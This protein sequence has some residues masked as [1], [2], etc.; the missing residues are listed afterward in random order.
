MCP[1]D[2]QT[3]ILIGGQ[4][5]RIQ[6]CKDSMWKLCT[7]QSVSHFTRQCDLCLV[8]SMSECSHVHPT[9]DMSWVAAETLAE[10]QTPE[11]RIGHTA[12]YDPDTRRIFLF[13][14]SKNNRWFND[15]HILDTQ[16]WKWTMVEVCTF[17]VSP[18]CCCLSSFFTPSFLVSPRLR[19]R[20]LLWPTKAA[21]CFV[22]NCS[23]WEVCFLVPTQSPTAAV[24]PCISLT[25]TSPSGTSLL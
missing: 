5:A 17:A 20:F 22:V 23:C 13:G 14:G 15:V 4:G 6:F 25:P 21:T 2:A 18:F 10:G 19:G 11:A 12:V 16:S 9:E 7:G 8:I 1:I 3:A 24:T